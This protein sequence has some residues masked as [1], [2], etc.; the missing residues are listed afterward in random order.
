MARSRRKTKDKVDRLTTL[1]AELLR[2]I[3]VYLQ[4]EELKRIASLCHATNAVATDVLTR[5]AGYFDDPSD[6]VINIDD[7]IVPRQLILH[8]LIRWLEFHNHQMVISTGEY[9]IHHTRSQVSDE[10]PDWVVLERR[11]ARAVTQGAL[12]EQATSPPANR[13][14]ILPSPAVSGRPHGTSWPWTASEFR[15]V[16]G[17]QSEKE[18][19]VTVEDVFAVLHSMRSKQRRWAEWAARKGTL[20]PETESA[21]RNCTLIWN[22]KTRILEAYTAAQ[23][24]SDSPEQ[25]VTGDNLPLRRLT[26]WR[27]IWS[28][29]M[30]MH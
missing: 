22:T 14:C 27:E 7:D 20:M 1:P 23:W 13:I 24:D 2:W 30:A 26:A 9:R 25:P 28:L 21:V 19:G 4:Y 15:V 12:E 18:R 16:V 29:L 8:P 11:G 3:F 6:N 5:C 17:A 10:R